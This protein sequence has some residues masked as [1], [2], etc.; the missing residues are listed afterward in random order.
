MSRDCKQCGH[1]LHEDS[2]FCSECGQKVTPI[3]C[4]RCGKS[5]PEDAKFCVYCGQAVGGELKERTTVVV[6]NIS[7]VAP[8]SPSSY[9]EK[10][11]SYFHKQFERIARGENGNF[12]WCAC[13]FG[14]LYCLYRDSIELLLRFYKVYLIFGAI[15][16]VLTIAI[17]Y[18]YGVTQGIVGLVTGARITTIVS[19]VVGFCSMIY[20]ILAGK[21]FNQGYYDHCLARNGRYSADMEQDTSVKKVLIGIAVGVAIAILTGI[22]SVTLNNQAVLKYLDQ[23]IPVSSYD[24]TVVMPED[25]TTTDQQTVTQQPSISFDYSE[26]VGSYSKADSSNSNIIDVELSLSTADTMEYYI[27]TT[28]TFMNQRFADISGS[29]PLDGSQTVTIIGEDSWLNEVEIVIEFLDKSG[30]ISV[31]S[32]VLESGEMANRSLSISP[33]TLSL[34]DSD[35]L[36][37]SNTQYIT[38]SELRRFTDEE[39]AIIRNEIYARHGYNFNSEFYQNY[40][41][42]KSWYYPISGLDASTFDTSVFNQYETENIKTIKEYE[43]TLTS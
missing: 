39:V 21:S 1:V 38:V 36:Y 13:F 35:Y 26:Y 11:Q 20:C 7:F 28:T 22:L 42:S 34:S 5:L 29:V 9:M 32:K 8:E 27:C 6:P 43:A 30:T 17:P 15:N 14:P 23:N 12:N 37:P 16:I 19:S 24:E 10:K 3:A 33:I 25:T 41:Y 18:Y 2:L 31:E 40:F 4:E